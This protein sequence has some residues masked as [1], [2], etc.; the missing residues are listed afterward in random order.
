MRAKVV[1]LIEACVA[2]DSQAEWQML[3]TGHSLGGALATLCAFELSKYTWGRGEEGGCIVCHGQLHSFYC[4]GAVKQ[5]LLVGCEA[6][7]CGMAKWH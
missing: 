4:V 2:G 6:A 5:V 7:E 1:D 3:C